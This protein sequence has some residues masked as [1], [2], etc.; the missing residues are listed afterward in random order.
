MV[1]QGKAS[2]RYLFENA[3][4]AAVLY[5]LENCSILDANKLALE[6]HGYDR[7]NFV[8]RDFASIQTDIVG[9]NTQLDELRNK[10][11]TSDFKT[12]HY[13]GGGPPIDVSVNSVVIDYGDRKAVMSSIRASEKTAGDTRKSGRRRRAGEA[14]VL[15]DSNLI[16]N[17]LIVYNGYVL[18]SAIKELLAGQNVR[19]THFLY[20]DN[21]SPSD[22]AFRRADFA[23][24]ALSGISALEI[25]DLK[26][27]CRERGDLPILVISLDAGVDAVV[28]LIRA[29]IRGVIIKDREF[30]L[31]PAA[32][33]AIMKGEF[34]FPR[35]I[36]QKFF[37]SYN[38]AT[39]LGK[40]PSRNGLLSDREGEI[41]SLIVKGLKNKEIAGKLGISYSTVLTHIY[42]I[43]RKLEVNS[44]SQA[45]RCALNTSLVKLS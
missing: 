5:D 16:K 25:E 44:R 4:D 33:N 3:P 31:I 32:V 26:S 13:R 2:Y 28:E 14:E 8:G 21:Y 34:W 35:A 7:N 43:Y 12:S 30:E 41:L 24:F 39:Y 40:P 11:R 1:A 36:M 10:G 37:E 20:P 45:I 22:H 6:L 17:L 29:G 19:C 23:I 9:F 27:L 15:I 18:H 42:N 38:Q